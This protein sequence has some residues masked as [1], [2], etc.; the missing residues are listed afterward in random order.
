M[1]WRKIND[2]FCGHALMMSWYPK[3]RLSDPRG[4]VMMDIDSWRSPGV[5]EVVEE[6]HEASCLM[7]KLL[8]KS[9]DPQKSFEPTHT[10]N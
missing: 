1:G 8:N 10:L 4:D 9:F 2:P 6:A 3:R 7:K 5:G